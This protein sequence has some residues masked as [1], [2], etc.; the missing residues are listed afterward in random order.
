MNTPAKCQC[1]SRIGYGYDGIRRAQYVQWYFRNRIERQALGIHA[2]GNVGRN[3]ARIAKGFGMEIYAYDPYCKP[4]VIERD[5]VKVLTSV[6]DLY[7][8]V[9]LFLCI[10]LLRKKLPNPLTPIFWGACPK[11]PSW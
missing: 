3:V 1:R 6:E 11:T 2:Y 5:G 10:F 7:K 4:E 9:R 8:N